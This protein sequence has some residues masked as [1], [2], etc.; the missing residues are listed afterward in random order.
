VTLAHP[1]ALWCLLGLPAVLAIHFLQRRSRREVVTTLFLLQQIRRQSA[2]GNRIDRLRASIPL[3]LQLLLVLVFTWLLAGPRWL[4]KDSVQRIAIVLDSSASMSAFRP[5]AE[6]AAAEA[7]QTLLPASSRT[8]LTLLSTDPGQPTLY[9]GAS[10]AGL[11]AALSEWQPTMGAHDFTPGLRMART[12]SGPQGTLVFIS[13]H[14]APE[15][16]PF[17]A[18]MISVGSPISN[19]GWA[20]LT[21]EEKD[22]QHL[23]RALLRNYGDKPQDRS[24][25]VIAQDT[26]SAPTP[27]RL[28]PGETRT[29]SG[30]FPPG[31]RLTLVLDA[32]AFPLDDQLP[33]LRP[34]PKVLSLQVPMIPL[35]DGS[36]ELRALFEKFADTRLVAS[37]SEA[38]VRGVVWPPTTALD[39]EQNAVVFAA[40]AKGGQVAWLRGSIVAEHHPLMEGLN[41]QSLLAQDGMVIP[42]DPKD[43][44]L[45][46]QDK[47]PLISLRRTPRGAQQL[48]CHFDLLDSNARR[49]PA[50]AILLHRFLQSVRQ[51]KIA[52]ESGNFDL[53]QKLIVACVRG[54]KA[55]P[56]QHETETPPSSAQIPS[57]RAH[58]LR[59]PARPGFF[60]VSQNGAVLL[61]GAAHFADIR[62]ADF[63]AASSHQDLSRAAK[64]QS[65]IVLE[66]NPHDPPW[67]L[68]ILCLLLAS[69]WFSHRPESIQPQARNTA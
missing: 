22:G 63:S 30:P 42:G 64:L 15:P 11:L 20:G 32:D 66:T 36:A 39:A 51:E 16:L 69:W 27:L 12:L 53:R 59:A 57:A 61:S 19:V 31:D 21:L 37:S 10:T 33:M 62:E 3:F 44:V 8:E 54:E 28:E 45:L 5:A 34:R 4:E 58:L 24:W 23:W 52:P 25:L 56:L 55:P 41:W 9:H 35:K 2:V 60:R 49:L 26:R 13:D 43:R 18:S 6:S 48:L 46:W 68:L 65:D 67:L 29:L 47:R 50:L 14:P 7:L 1:A 17:E 40:P 38:D